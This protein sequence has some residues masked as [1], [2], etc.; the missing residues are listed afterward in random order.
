MSLEMRLGKRGNLLT[1]GPESYAQVW[2]LPAACCLPAQCK[3]C[4]LPRYSMCT[5][6]QRCLINLQVM[7]PSPVLLEDELTSVVNCGLNNQTFTLHYTTGSP[8]AMKNALQQLCTDVEAAVKGGCEIVIL[9]DRLTDGEEV[10]LDQ[11]V[12]QH[13][14]TLCNVLSA[15]AQCSVVPVC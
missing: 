4:L 13:D 9:S 5:S 8:D 12:V 2:P 11:R 6:A 7:L 15:H 14:C 1:P 3:T 10:R